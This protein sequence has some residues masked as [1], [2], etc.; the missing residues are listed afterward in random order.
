MHLINYDEKDSENDTSL[1]MVP[2]VAMGVS[3]ST[4]K[5][6]EVCIAKLGQAAFEKFITTPRGVALLQMGELVTKVATHKRED[7]EVGP[8]RMIIKECTSERPAMVIMFRHH[9]PSIRPVEL[10]HFYAAMGLSDQHEVQQMLLGRF[11]DLTLTVC[12]TQVAVD[13]FSLSGY[14]LQNVADEGS[15][16]ALEERWSTLA[17][18]S[19]PRLSFDHNDVEKKMLKHKLPDYPT[20]RQ[21]VQLLVTEKLRPR[22][23]SVKGNC[24]NEALFR[25][26]LKLGIS[27]SSSAG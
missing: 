24:V 18:N 13:F 4:E 11:R 9:D 8:Y 16:G 22:H 1:V 25:L 23:F 3:N 6:L 27:S 7:H 20:V 17:P 15:K 21:C 19:V 2:V 12:L 14:V 10:M 26:Q 5:Q